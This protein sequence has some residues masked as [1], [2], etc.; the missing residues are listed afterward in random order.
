MTTT[1]NSLTSN[2]KAMITGY[3]DLEEDQEEVE[4]KEYKVA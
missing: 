3:E 1:G 2:I 4:E